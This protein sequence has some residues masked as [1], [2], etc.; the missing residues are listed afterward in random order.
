[1]NRPCDEDTELKAW[2]KH[3]CTLTESF[4]AE[5][6]C[7]ARTLSVMHVHCLFGVYP[8]ALQLGMVV[9]VYKN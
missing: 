2:H 6:Q 5:V 1:M 7:H 8:K 4:S 3:D 9:G